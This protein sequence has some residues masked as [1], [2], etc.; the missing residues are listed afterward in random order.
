MINKADEVI[1]R[2]QKHIRRLLQRLGVMPEGSE[3]G[4]LENED[5]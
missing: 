3:A 2:G 4:S 1:D 5:A